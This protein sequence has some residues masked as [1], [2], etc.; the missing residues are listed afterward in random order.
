M[1]GHCKYFA[2]NLT[3]PKCKHEESGFRDEQ[4]HCPNCNTVM[5]ESS[6]MNHRTANI[7]GCR[8]NDKGNNNGN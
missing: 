3:C 4:N 1:T 7:R 8:I 2:V 6:R 5:I